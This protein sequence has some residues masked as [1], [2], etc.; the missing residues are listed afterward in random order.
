M[1]CNASAGS[2]LPEQGLTP[3]MPHAQNMLDKSMPLK[4]PAASGRMRCSPTASSTAPSSGL[5]C[6]KGTPIRA[7]STDCHS[8]QNLL[9]RSTPL[10]APAASSRISVPQMRPTPRHPVDPPAMKGCE[11]IIAAML[12]LQLSWFRRRITHAISGQYLQH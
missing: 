11:G 6:M 5:T 3:R 1:T 7:L 10:G 2:I 12:A 9:D 4:V 8:A